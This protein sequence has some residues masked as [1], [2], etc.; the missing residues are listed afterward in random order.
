MDFLKKNE[1]IVVEDII[2]EG[3]FGIVMLALKEDQK[4][5]VKCILKKYDIKKDDMEKVK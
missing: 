1:K 2:G 4:L 5:A 3:E